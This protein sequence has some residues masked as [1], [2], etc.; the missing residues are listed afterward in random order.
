MSSTS[1]SRRRFIKLGIAGA[2]GAGIASAIEIP[3]LGN[4]YI[5]DNATISKQESQIQQLQNQVNQIPKLQTQ[6]LDTEAIKTL[7]QTEAVELEALIETIIPTDDNGPGGK[8]AGVLNFIDTVL[9]GDY[10]NNSRMYMKGPFIAAGAT[11]PL[12]VNGTTYAQGSP[13]E[14][15]IG[16]TYQYNMTLREFWRSGLS[17]LEDYAKSNYGNNV[18]SL[19]NDQRVKLLTDLFNGKP[20]NFKILPLDFFSELMFVVWS[21]FLMDPMYGGNRGMV[22][23]KLVGFTGTN[24]GN[25]YGEGLNSQTLMVAATP[26]R[27]Q[28]ASNGQYQQELGLLPGGSIA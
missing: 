14:P 5:N 11:G 6:V 26:T 18:E 7:S 19:S 1:Q 9:T 22:G 13:G 15:F 12:T 27:L 3:F 25:A 8:E 24:M 17:S 21:G 4:A 16:P 2:V 20:T 10:G 28:P 23:W